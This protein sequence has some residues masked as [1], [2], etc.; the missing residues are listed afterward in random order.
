M[1]WT[2]LFPS[3]VG[4]FES[5][6]DALT[7]WIVLHMV[8]LSENKMQDFYRSMLTIFF[9]PLT[10]RSKIKSGVRII[11][12]NLNKSLSH[13][14]SQQP[15]SFGLSTLI[16]HTPPTQACR[17]A[18]LADPPAGPGQPIRPTGTGRPAE[19]QSPSPH[20]WQLITTQLG[21]CTSTHS[22]LT[23]TGLPDACLTFKRII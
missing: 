9:Q 23:N 10:W 4:I 1:P 6:I 11:V 18:E 17:A 20:S 14:M 16:C 3:I 12:N 22:L 13:R 2:L 5:T 7:P 15:V 8:A 21:R 19:S